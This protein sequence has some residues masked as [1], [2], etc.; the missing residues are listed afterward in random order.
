MVLKEKAALIN[1]EKC[2]MDKLWNI[3]AMALIKKITASERLYHHQIVPY[4]K[5]RL[6]V[7][8]FGSVHIN[9]IRC[10]TFGSINIDYLVESAELGAIEVPS[11]RLHQNGMLDDDIV[12]ADSEQVFDHYLNKLNLIY[13]HILQFS[14]RA[15]Q[16]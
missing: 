10:G 15:G 8:V 16:E 7:R 3:Y 12:L 11:S 9:I 6:L 14:A 1:A 2:K 13:N 4:Q 5:D